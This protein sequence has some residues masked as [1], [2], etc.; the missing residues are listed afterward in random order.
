MVEKGTFETLSPEP[1]VVDH[2]GTCVGIGL[3]DSWNSE[4]SLLHLSS[5]DDELEERI[6]E[7]VNELDLKKS[8]EAVLGGT[9]SSRYDPHIEDGFYED[10][11]SRVE[12]AMDNHGLEYHSSWND[13]PVYNRMILSPEYGVFYDAIL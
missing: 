2:L 12:N 7:F 10:V 6:E 5:R 4:V 11:R 1:L 3:Y 9:I 13:E 8:Y